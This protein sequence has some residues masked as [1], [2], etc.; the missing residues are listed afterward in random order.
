MEQDG[1]FDF[2]R[3]RRPLE[4]MGTVERLFAYDRESGGE[5]VL[6][7]IDEA[8]RGPWAGPVVAAAVIFPPDT[9]PLSLV[10][11]NDSKKITERRRERLAE[12]IQDLALATGIGIASAREIDLQNIEKA[13]FLAMGRALLDC[14]VIPDLAVVDG[15]RD[16]GLG[17]PTRTVV[18]GDGTS[19]AVAAASILAKTHRDRHM[20]LLGGTEDR[21]GFG[22]HKGYGTEHHKRALSVFGISDHHRKTFQPV[23]RAIDRPEASPLF[24]EL[25]EDL[26]EVKNPITLSEVR[27]KIQVAN[28]VLGGDEAWILSRRLDFLAQ[29]LET[30]NKSGGAR[31]KGTFHE[32]AVLGYLSEKGY[33][34]LETNYQIQGGE[35]DIV[36]RQGETIV[37]IEVKMRGSDR[38]GEAGAALTPIKRE[39]IVRAAR[40]Y[41]AAAGEGVDCRF[42]VIALDNP[43][44][45]ATHLEHFQN[46]FEVPDEPFA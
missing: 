42:D 4:A 31:A 10:G 20:K 29:S 1:L 15:H 37:F 9:D 40:R 46:A 5:R 33:T 13:T 32:S 44:G 26:L 28:Q 19:A 45:G 8:G 41:L 36:A 16:P 34:L 35:I 17:I 27:L 18:R 39:R 6:A 22:L 2:E 3:G 12:R 43:K 14:G 25:W 24:W 30:E 21:W 7:G 11:L 38:Y 23:A